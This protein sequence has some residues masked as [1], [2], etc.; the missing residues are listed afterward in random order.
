MI[1]IKGMQKILF[2]DRDGTLVLEPHDYQVDAFDK[3]EFY[4][5]VFQYLGKIVRELDF[6]LVMVTNQDGMGTE[7]YPEEHFWGPHKLIMK[8]FANEGIEFKEVIIDK[9]FAHENAPTR[10]P[11]TGLLTHY[12]DGSYDLANSFVIGD[13]LTDMQLAKNLGAKG[14]WLNQD[15]E[16]GANELDDKT[17]SLLDEVI[18]LTT[19][20]W[21]EIYSFLKLTTRS[22]SIQR[23]T[24]ETDIRIELNL[25]GSGKA[26]NHTG[27][28][29]F[30]HMLDQLARHSS[31]DLTVQVQGD[32]H[33]DEHHTIEDTALALG[34][35]FAQ[36]LGDKLGIERYGF[37]LPMDDCLAQVAID[38]GGRPWLVWE[39][40]FKREKIGEMPT[41]MFYHFFK[42]FSDAAKCNLNVKAEGTNE[43]HKIEAIFKAFAKAI[44]MAKRR[45]VENMQ[46]P[47]TKGVL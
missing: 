32:L 3:I 33:I 8:A 44:K 6:E 25:D 38:F 20:E 39:A 26:N 30:D 35:A 13:R 21:S 23:T 40:E 31:C 12:L 41:E 4:P 22:A 2:L 29:F 27:L 17:K 15:P 43:H 11:H 46:L 5:R 9:T 34:E 16:L 37:C 24:K 19:L 47:S 10:K 36:A 14:I 45:D 18:A 1:N 28:G 42:S 7:A